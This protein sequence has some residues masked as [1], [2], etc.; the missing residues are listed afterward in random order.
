MKRFFAIVLMVALCSSI[1]GVQAFAATNIP[2]VTDPSVVTD[3]PMMTDTQLQTEDTA[4]SGYTAAANIEP[5]AAN[6]PSYSSL[7][8]L[9]SGTYTASLI[10]LAAGKNSYTLKCFITSTGTINLTCLFSPSGTSTNTDRELVAELYEYSVWY[11]DGFNQHYVTKLVDTET[12]SYSTAGVGTV[13]KYHSFTNLSNSS[14]YYILFK[15]TSGTE[16]KSGLDIS[17]S[18]GIYE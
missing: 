4:D 11:D 14:H 13:T 18:I 7:W 15:N 8:N 12:I 10:D 16:A 3:I 9:A 1:L 2:V 6:E 5:Y 17:A